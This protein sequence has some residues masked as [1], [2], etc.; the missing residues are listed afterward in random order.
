MSENTLPRTSPNLSEVLESDFWEKSLEHISDAVLI[1][2]AEPFDD[3]GPKILW[4]N[5]A[6][7]QLTGYSASDVTGK[8]PRML[9]GPLTDKSALKVVRASL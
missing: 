2:E 9:Q 5:G 7:Y 8:T 6:F 3:P 1:T 4:A